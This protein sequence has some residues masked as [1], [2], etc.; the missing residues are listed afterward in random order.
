MDRRRLRLQQQTLSSRWNDVQAFTMQL[1]NFHIEFHKFTATIAAET[2]TIKLC[3]SKTWVA[4]ILFRP[5]VFGAMNVAIKIDSLSFLQ[6]IR[7]ITMFQ[8][9][10]E[11]NCSIISERTCSL[12]SLRISTHTRMIICAK[13]EMNKCCE[14]GKPSNKI[15]YSPNP[16]EP[17]VMN[18]SNDSF[19]SPVFLFFLCFVSCNS[20][21]TKSMVLPT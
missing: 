4:A 7:T 11:W 10:V 6:T 8:E 14:K 21:R 16:F 15:H 3:S 2:T 19:V 5:I 9:D 13:R 18:G 1:S 12:L 20:I 17:S